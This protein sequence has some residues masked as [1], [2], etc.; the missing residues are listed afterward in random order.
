[1]GEYIITA[2]RKGDTWYVGGLNNWDARDVEVDLSF[3]S[4]GSHKAV[5]FK[6]GV[7]LI[8]LHAITS[9]KK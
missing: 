7:M 1:M 4:S 5:L 3:L 8:V 6:D 9:A 2:R